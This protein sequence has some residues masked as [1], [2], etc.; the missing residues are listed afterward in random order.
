MNIKNILW[1][2]FMSHGFRWLLFFSVLI[3]N[4]IAYYQDP[5]RYTIRP[6]CY[7]N[8]PCKWFNYTAGMMTFTMDIITFIGLWYT[9]APSWLLNSL[10]QFWFIP[11][12]LLG[13]AIIT[14]ITI[15]SS[16]IEDHKEILA[17]PPSGIW[18]KQWRII[19][20]TI[21]LLIDTIVFAQM[22]IDSGVNDY[23]KKFK[24]FD[25]VVKGR[26]GGWSN[27]NYVQFLFSWMAII[28][29][30]IDILSLYFVA[31]YNSCYYELPISW[32]F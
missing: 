19:L 21:I 29:V 25:F 9:I 20:Y 30:C 4:F 6:K 8:T 31:T 16:T 3:L 12:I 18:P 7:F 2:T 24:I 10:P 11:F 14:Q 5:T 27:G 23:T 28:G 22:Y 13:Y 17:S 32:N 1:S 26:F 15:D